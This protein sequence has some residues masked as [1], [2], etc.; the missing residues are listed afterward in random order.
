MISS[1][2]YFTL[3]LSFFKTNWPIWILLQSKKSSIKNFLNTIKN[4]K[5]I[6]TLE[7]HILAGGLGGI[8]AELLFDNKINKKLDLIRMG[9]DINKI[10]TYKPR[11]LIH[12]INKITANDVVKKILN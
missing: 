8:I 10:Y 7:E 1:Q 11:N 12:R 2:I 5:L 6:V 3:K 9:I 4:A